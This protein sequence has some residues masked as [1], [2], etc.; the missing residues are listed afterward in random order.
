MF[1]RILYAWNAVSLR[2]FPSFPGSRLHFFIAGQIQHRTVHRFLYTLVQVD[3]PCRLEAQ[4]ARNQQLK[5][6]VICFEEKI[7]NCFAYI[8]QHY[9]L[10]R[11]KMFLHVVYYRECT[12]AAV[13]STRRTL[14]SKKAESN[15]RETTVL[16]CSRTS[17]C[18]LL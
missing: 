9:L 6:C 2:I 3:A 15:Y 10:Q 17:A 16:T 7:E 14:R 18:Q 4:Y 12:A 5:K 1:S 11:M 13:R 8:A